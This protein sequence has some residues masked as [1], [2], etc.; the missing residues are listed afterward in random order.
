VDELWFFNALQQP[1]IA[2]WQPQNAYNIMS[3]DK[4][5]GNPI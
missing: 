3:S 2:S 5:P 4:L 1:W